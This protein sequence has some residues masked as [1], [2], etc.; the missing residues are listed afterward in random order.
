MLRNQREA[1]SDNAEESSDSIVDQFRHLVS[2]FTSSQAAASAGPAS[3]GAGG[4][5]PLLPLGGDSLAVPPLNMTLP[6]LADLGGYPP[7]SNVAPA[8]PASGGLLAALPTQSYDLQ[9]L[10]KIG[11]SFT[12]DQDGGVFVPPFDK[13]GP[14]IR[15]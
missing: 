4:H 3:P 10:L 9:N 14:L 5:A 8:F 1:R 13:D 12:P 11:N 7:I 6:Q 2:V 15:G